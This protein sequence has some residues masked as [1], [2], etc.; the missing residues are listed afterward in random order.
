VPDAA[1]LVNF[2]I[3]GAAKIIGV[4]NGD[5]SSHEPDQ[6]LAGGWKRSLFNG[7]C[8]LILQ[9]GTDPETVIIRAAS[10]GIL[11]AEESIVIK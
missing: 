2:S 9:A 8:Q 1:N 11:M 5:P 7:H 3:K 6:Y 10:A 4:G